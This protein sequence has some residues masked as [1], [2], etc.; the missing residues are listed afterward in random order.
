MI[1]L[2][3]SCAA[4]GLSY[5]A[6]KQQTT[7]HRVATFLDL[8]LKVCCG[9]KGGEP[10]RLF[11]IANFFNL[12]VNPVHVKRHRRISEPHLSM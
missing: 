6:L 5:T 1:L 3:S 7:I 9:S 2:N 8:Q 4:L 11:S 12:V 10:C